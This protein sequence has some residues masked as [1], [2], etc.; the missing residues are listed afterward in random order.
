MTARPGADPE[1]REMFARIPKV[2]AVRPARRG[3][4][5][6]LAGW[7]R[8]HWNAFAVAAVGLFILY[9]GPTALG[10]GASA[11][12]VTGAAVALGAFVAASY[13]PAPGARVD[14]SP[15]ALMPLLW[16]VA[17]VPWAFGTAGMNPVVALGVLA[18]F[19]VQRATGVGCR[20]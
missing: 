9:G 1:L 4:L 15:C 6:G 7:G 5:R 18:V 3:A 2:D 10:G 11:L 12:A 13:V 8:R 20:V 17:F 14:L 16:A 19:A